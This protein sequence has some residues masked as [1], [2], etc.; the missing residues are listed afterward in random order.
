MMETGIIQI[1]T[2]ERAIGDKSVINHNLLLNSSTLNNSNT[3]N[4]SS[5]H[6]DKSI[7]RTLIINSSH[8]H[9]NSF[10]N[11]RFVTK[12]NCLSLL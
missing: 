8:K 4:N 12:I 1:I 2:L 5:N 3:L 10:P 11:N 6:L 9:N 7:L